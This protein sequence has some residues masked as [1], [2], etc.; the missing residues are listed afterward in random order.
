M[1][2]KNE[3]KILNNKVLD[4]IV[5][6]PA[7]II[8]IIYASGFFIWNIYLSTFS[9]FEY[10]LIQ[11][12][13]LSAGILLWLPVFL[14]YFFIKNKKY[15]YFSAIVSMFLVILCFP[16]IPQYIGGARPIP[17]MILGSSD[18]ISF[19][20]NYNVRKTENAGQD[21]VQTGTVC[22][23]YQNDNYVLFFNATD[24]S[25]VTQTY[26]VRNLS[27]VRDKFS[28]FQQ[29]ADESDSK[30][31]CGLSNLWFWSELINKFKK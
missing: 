27:I 24:F 31:Q 14:L 20:N 25:M 29:A 9:F 2:E 12:R 11:I 5:K 28:G 10:N 13:Y 26:K 21:S 8:F 19:L 4:I 7:W 15:F 6:Y 23:I 3:H 17:I 16:L 18:Q 1:E 22:L 30:I